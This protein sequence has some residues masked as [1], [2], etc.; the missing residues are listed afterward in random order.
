[1]LA[2]NHYI[3]P[4]L[5]KFLKVA[6]VS[7]NTQGLVIALHSHPFYPA[8]S[9][10]SQALIY[11]G[12]ENKVYHADYDGILAKSSIALVHLNGEGN[13]FVLLLKTTDDE[14]FYYDALENRYITLSKDEFIRQW[15]G[16]VLYLTDN[17]L[18]TVYS[19]KSG[20]VILSGL[21]IVM[22]WGGIL[23][24]IITLFYFNR[25][26]YLII[27][28]L[29][30]AGIIVSVGL[31][32]HTLN[33][34]TGVI[35]AICR[36]AESF[37]CNKVL[38]SPV[39]RLGRVISLSGI[40][41][42]YFTTGMVSVIIG[43]IARCEQ[44]VI[45]LLFYISVCCLPFIIF[46]VLYQG[47]ILRKWCPLCMGVV[48]ILMTENILFYFYTEKQFLIT[49]IWRAGTVVLFSF[50]MAALIFVFLE[51]TVKQRV[52]IRNEEIAVLKLKRNPLVVSVLF[53]SQT[54]ILTSVP[55]P[56]ILGDET[57]SV[58][59]TTVINPFCHPCSKVVNAIFKLLE[60]FPDK[61]KWE[62][63]FDG[64]E[65]DINNPGNKAQ[66]YLLE[67]YKKTKDKNIYLRI[68]KEWFKNPSLELFRNKYPLAEVSV[69]TIRQFQFQLRENKVKVIDKL[70][71]VVINQ[72]VMPGE[73]T[74][75][76]IGYLLSDGKLLATVTSMDITGKV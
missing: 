61:I 73:Y 35:A 50:C 31:I 41:M 1:M 12:I 62:I 71:Y 34:N 45:L 72:R 39:S 46:S 22:L 33:D 30:L 27:L 13:R 2:D 10:V 60:K 32:G 40:G 64:I 42:I 48:S 38:K 52:K 43:Y 37:D 29:K 11:V 68:L 16:T 36:S 55:S 67:L 3:I 28:L 66:L 19:P 69:D 59:I 57:A 49:E 5:D 8:I 75:S 65:A 21:G 53:R 44:T 9:S 25:S 23:V 58:L 7:Y 18:K 74:I 15:S 14:V 54:P 4:L 26:E 17:S 6:G 70:P 63:G 24:I 47:F 56:V 51:T 20:S 76:D